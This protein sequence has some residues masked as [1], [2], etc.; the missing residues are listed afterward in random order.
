MIVFLT[1]KNKDEYFEELFNFCKR[2]YT[3]DPIFQNYDVNDWENKPHTLL[4]LLYKEKRFDECGYGVYIKDD[5]IIAGSGMYRSELHPDVFVFACRT[6]KDKD[7]K[8]YDKTTVR[9]IWSEQVKIL[10]E[11]KALGI[12][13]TYDI[14]KEKRMFELFEKDP[15]L[16]E[17]SRL[18]NNSIP[19]LQNLKILDKPITIKGTVQRVI[20]KFFDENKNWDKIPVKI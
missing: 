14:N 17:S 13:I 18:I 6:L 4:Y 12:I 19:D 10:K 20:Y 9:E 3:N 8:G 15:K 16:L 11:K 5:E 1:S 7:Y 2:N